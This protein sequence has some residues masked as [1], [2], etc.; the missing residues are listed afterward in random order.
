MK[1]DY[2]SIADSAKTPLLHK[3]DAS[4]KSRF[5]FLFIGSLLVTAVLG[6]FAIQ[7]PIR[8]LRS[9]TRP[10]PPPRRFLCTSA[11]RRFRCSPH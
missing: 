10:P 3:D 11:L 7:M 1:A 8:S 9:T 4:S 6:T 2:N 5:S